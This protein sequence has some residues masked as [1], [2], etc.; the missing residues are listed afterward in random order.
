MFYKGH[1]T[2]SFKQR[3][4]GLVFYPHGT[5][6][7]GYLIAPAERPALEAYIR[8]WSYWAV[9]LVGLQI[10]LN[11]LVGWQYSLIV[12]L[13]GLAILIS[14][15]YVRMRR[16]SAERIPAVARLS[17]QESIEN[18]ARAM[19]VSWLCTLLISCLL[20]FFA[21]IWLLTTPSESDRFALWLGPLFLGYGTYHFIKLAIARLRLARA[22]HPDANRI[23]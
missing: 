4:E 6:A 18:Q 16:W 8:R 23:K 11:T 2:V 7:R 22:A 13:P 5:L 17:L 15:Y 12:S 21:S 10:A 1:E 20:G 19:P 9:A 3:E 14:I